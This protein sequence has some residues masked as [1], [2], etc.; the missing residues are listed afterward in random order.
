M[1]VTTDQKVYKDILTRLTPFK[2]H[3]HLQK[4]LKS[5]S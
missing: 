5:L 3:D 2:N 1:K 4:N